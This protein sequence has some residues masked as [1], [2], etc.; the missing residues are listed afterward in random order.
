MQQQ[1]PTLQQRLL[2]F[3]VWLLATACCLYEQIRTHWITQWMWQ[4]T[5]SMYKFVRRWIS[6][7]F[8]PTHVP[9]TNVVIA[10]CGKKGSGKDTTAMKLRK[11]MWHLDGSLF[12]HRTFAEPLKQTVQL[13][14]NCSSDKLHTHEG[15]ESI[16]PNKFHPEPETYRDILKHVGKATRRFLA[17]WI[18]QKWQRDRQMMKFLHLPNNWILSDL[19]LVDELKW[20]RSLCSSDTHVFVIRVVSDKSDS[21]SDISETSIDTFDASEI[22]FTIRNT[23]WDDNM[24]NLDLQCKQLCQVIVK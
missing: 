14:T 11:W 16:F 15:K 2:Y 12:R 22:N 10:I 8:A 24:E 7:V 23:K 1:Q 4:Q 6:Y 18:D 17:N 13:L 5:Q 21:D 9:P 20:V 19:R 3:T